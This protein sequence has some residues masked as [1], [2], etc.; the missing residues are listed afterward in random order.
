MAATGIKQVGKGVTQNLEAMVSRG[1]DSRAF[2]ARVA[3]P[4]YQARQMKRWMTEN[5]SEGETWKPL[6]TKYAEWKRINFAGY[7]GNGEKTLIRTSR[8]IVGVIGR[9]LQGNPESIEQSAEGKFSEKGS[10]GMAVSGRAPGHFVL[11]DERSMVV[12]TD[13]PYSKFVCER[14]PFFDFNPQFKKDIKKRYAQW[15][16]TGEVKTR[17]K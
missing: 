9:V 5:A 14:R 15:F 17:G 7:P 12:S 2:F 4:M 8:L 16:T 10:M 3:Y 6:N 1:K 13:V 11:I